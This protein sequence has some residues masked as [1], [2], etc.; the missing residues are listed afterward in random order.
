V[1]V[2]DCVVEL[3]SVSLAVY[4]AVVAVELVLVS[5]RVKIL[6]R[7]L[8]GLCVCLIRVCSRPVVPDSASSSVVSWNR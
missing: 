4:G 6:L 8:G 2:V 7:I 1:F 3:V 5:C